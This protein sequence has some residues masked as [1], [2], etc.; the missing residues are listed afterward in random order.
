MAEQ[1][2]DSFS[3]RDTVWGPD[4]RPLRRVDKIA[5]SERDEFAQTGVDFS[6]MKNVSAQ[7]NENRIIE[8]AEENIKHMSPEFRKLLKSMGAI[9][10]ETFDE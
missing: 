9:G 5:K 10:D 1:L 2:P 8:A 4:G 6:G 7:E 3:Q